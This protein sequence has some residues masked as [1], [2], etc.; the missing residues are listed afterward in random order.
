MHYEQRP[1]YFLCDMPPEATLSSNMVLEAIDALQRNA[2]SFLHPRTIEQQVSLV[3]QLAK[4]W[5]DDMFPY[6]CE[7]LKHCGGEIRFSREI[8]SHG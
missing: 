3:E 7:L 2:T 8:F 4:L 1:N 5:M 6:R